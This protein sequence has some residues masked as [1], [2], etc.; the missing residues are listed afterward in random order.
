MTDTPLRVTLFHER[1]RIYDA[2]EH[3]GR[4]IVA[5]PPVPWATLRIFVERSG[6]FTERYYFQSEADRATDQRTLE[7]QLANREREA[8]VE[9]GTTRFERTAPVWDANRAAGVV[10]PTQAE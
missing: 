8:P 7:R 1:Y 4:T 5:N 10:P 6:F 9:K 2:T 3:K